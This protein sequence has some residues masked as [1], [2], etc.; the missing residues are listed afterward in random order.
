MKKKFIDIE[1]YKNIEK[2]SLTAAEREL[3]K[4]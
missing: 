2:N 4:L 1:T 3:H